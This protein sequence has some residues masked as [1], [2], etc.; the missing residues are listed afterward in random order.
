MAKS[1]QSRGK[2]G[3]DAARLALAS[4]GFK[5]IE[6][7]GTPVRLV[8]HPFVDGYFRVIYGERVAADFRAVGPLGVS[9]MAEV[10]TVDTLRWSDFRAH[11]PD[12]L[13]EHEAC[14]G[15]SLVA[16]VRDE[17]YIMRWC[18]MLAAGFAPRKSLSVAQ[19]RALRVRA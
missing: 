15:V 1:S 13:S 2:A 19:A 3:E 16:W 4:A 11:Q 8:K 18:D 5:M 6:R 17:V 10:K 14:G 7:I 9:V 12:A